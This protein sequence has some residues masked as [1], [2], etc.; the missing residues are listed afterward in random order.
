MILKKGRAAFCMYL[1]AEK[2]TKSKCKG[3]SHRKGR[4]ELGCLSNV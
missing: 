2:I 3:D 4:L 1:A